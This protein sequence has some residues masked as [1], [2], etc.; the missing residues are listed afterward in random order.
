MSGQ[1]AAG[2]TSTTRP[3]STLHDVVSLQSA[4]ADLRDAYEQ[5]TQVV[6]AASPDELRAPTRTDWSVRELLVHVLLDAQRGLVTFAT[7]AACTPDTDRVTYWSRFAN[8]SSAGSADAH[9]R[10][11]AT[12]AG[13][14]QRDAGLVA[15]WTETSAATARAA[16]SAP[17]PV[18]TTQ[19]CSLPVADFV[20]TLVVEAAIHYLDLTAHLAAPALHDAAL[21]RAVAVV[22]ALLPTPAPAT[23]SDVDLVLRAT[24]R[25]SLTGE[26]S[27]ALR[28]AV[29]V[30]S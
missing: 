16:L 14:Y 22:R 19:G 6:A 15:H 9:R 7:P 23:W 27:D 20:D 3:L 12:V 24:G 11:V 4:A 26:E 30:L 18:V 1:C 25:M 5:I 29:P 10:W 21:G 28:A 2:G 17:A 13:A 8:A